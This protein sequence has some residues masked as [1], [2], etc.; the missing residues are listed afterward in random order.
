MSMTAE[1]FRE[2][3]QKCYYRLNSDKYAKARAI[4]PRVERLLERNYYSRTGSINWKKAEQIFKTEFESCV[5]GSEFECRID[6]P[7]HRYALAYKI[8]EY[9]GIEGHLAKR[10]FADN[11]I[12][13]LWSVEPLI[14]N[15]KIK[16]GKK[17]KFLFFFNIDEWRPLTFEE[18][19]EILKAD[20]DSLHRQIKR[21]SINYYPDVD[22]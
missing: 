18:A 20:R 16:T 1:Q 4:L 7:E 19:R 9:L 22:D 10:Y 12:C 5:E 11:I 15:C 3:A 2:E 13:P 8:A 17:K 6:T 21:L 14:C